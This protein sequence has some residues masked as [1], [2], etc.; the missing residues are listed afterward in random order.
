M[1]TSEVGQDKRE[2]GNRTVHR[3]GGDEIDIPGYYHP[4]YSLKKLRLFAFPP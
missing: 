1:G 2:N 4:F 3:I